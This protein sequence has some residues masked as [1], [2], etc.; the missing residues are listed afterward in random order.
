ML[1]S[2]LNLNP[3]CSITDSFLLFYSVLSGLCIFFDNGGHIRYHAENNHPPIIDKEMFEKV[4]AERSRR[5]NIE[6]TDEGK[7]R[8]SEK[9]SSK[10]PNF[11]K[12]HDDE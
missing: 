11:D 5:T 4:Q 2:C 10:R 1:K 12:I 6:I 9:Y 8:K 3:S 7:K